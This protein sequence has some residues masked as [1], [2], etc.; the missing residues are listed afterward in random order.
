MELNEAAML[1]AQRMQRRRL[2]FLRL[3]IVLVVGG[4]LVF[5]GS[6]W[7]LAQ[8]EESRTEA[9]QTWFAPYVDVTL[10]PLLH[11]EDPAEQP[12]QN[13]VLGFIVADPAKAC[14][15]SWGTYYSLDAAARAL[16]LD[17]RIVRLRERGGDAVVSFGGALNNELA[18][19]CT[20]ADALVAAY[21]SVIDRY[22]SRIL[23]FDIEG[24]S[25]ADVAAN[26]RRAN[27]IRRL[28]EK[29]SGLQ[30][31]FTLPVAPHGLEAESV[32]LLEQA[33][34]ANVALTGIN[35]MTMNYGG[36]RAPSDSMGSATAAA[37]N[38]THLQIDDAYRRAGTLKTQQEL[39]QMLGATPMIGQNDVASD[40][41]TPSDADSLI[42]LAN[43]VRLGRI[44]FWSANRD[45][46]CGVSVTDKRASN[47]CSGV[48]QEPLEFG[49]R[50]SGAV[51]KKSP[52]KQANPTPASG[53]SRVDGLSR[54]DPRTS[55]YPIWRSPKAYETGAKVVWQARVYQA[56]WWSQGDQPDAPV[57]HIWETPWRY[58]GPVL[59]SDREA[60][61]AGDSPLAD[62]TRSRWSAERVFV[63]GDQVELENQIFR[64]KWW[65]QGDTPQQDP[66]QP[67]SHPWEY[68]GKVKLQADD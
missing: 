62:G 15:P 12:A 64:A 24:A 46:Q 57:K 56:K 47:T 40:V 30:V 58:L 2:S 10:T 1:P 49:A 22:Q 29:N 34:A 39:W 61:R 20:D 50:F 65:T 6:R 16:D 43:D 18:T 31:W 35:A 19:V 68:L 44:S 51:G 37:L 54:D 4:G 13:V 32:A 66:D 59:E 5:A 42:A 36:S 53:D 60:V 28:Q 8:L 55:P 33:I 7:A 27:A 3:L 26:A 9:T 17:R 67:Y 23:D 63:A 48:E 45:V 21:Q 25:L 52:P 14:V 41:F 38:A 11:F